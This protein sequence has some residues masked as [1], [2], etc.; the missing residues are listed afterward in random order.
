M[1]LLLL[2]ILL[3]FWSIYLHY[4][5]NSFLCSFLG[6]RL[7]LL[8]SGTCSGLNRNCYV[9][10]YGNNCN[11]N[12]SSRSC[13]NSGY[14]KK[15]E[16]KIDSINICSLDDVYQNSFP[17]KHTKNHEIKLRKQKDSYDGDSNDK[18]ND[19][20]YNK[21]SSGRERER[22]SDQHLSRIERK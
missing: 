1:L 3:F 15:K 10:T 7:G 8:V 13:N 21:K 14:Q 5:F 22:E 18:S 19:R 11:C 6:M 9:S 2:L 20:I 12:S 16:N 17:L 4:F